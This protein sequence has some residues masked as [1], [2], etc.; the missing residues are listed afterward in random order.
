MENNLVDRETDEP[1]GRVGSILCV[2]AAG[3][4]SRFDEQLGCPNAVAW[5]PDGSTFYFADSMD[6]W[7]YASDFDE[8][9]G[10]F[11]RRRPFFAAPDMGVPDGAAVDA[12]GYVWNARWGAGCVIRIAPDGTVDRVVD[13]PA[14]F[15]TSC[16]FG[17]VDRKTLYITSAQNGD[18]NP[19]AGGVFT[20]RT[21]VAGMAPARFGQTSAALR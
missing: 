10:N 18:D 5:S 8:E 6:G 17:G 15:V 9:A 21:S 1:L 20:L 11:S 14:T 19:S 7:I 13:V 16:V 3:V 2:T 12:E 4:V